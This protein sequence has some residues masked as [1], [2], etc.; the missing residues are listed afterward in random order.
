MKTTILI[1]YAKTDASGNP[2]GAPKVIS[3]PPGDEGEAREQAR[4]FSDAKQKHQFPKGVKYLAFGNIEIADVAVH[5]SDEVADQISGRE[6]QQRLA[7]EA[8][9]KKAAE[10]RKKI[11]AL[12]A[13]TQVVSSAA[14]AHNTAAANLKTAKDRVLDAEANNKLAKTDGTAAALKAAKEKVTELETAEAK[15]AKVLAEAK[16]AKAELLNPKK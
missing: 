3:G 4:V 8:L 5:I 16:A 9:E 10:A 14:V 1:G 15:A 2:Q 13:A 11:A 6:S 7:A 12:A